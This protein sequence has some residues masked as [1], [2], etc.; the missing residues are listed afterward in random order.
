MSPACCITALHAEVRRRLQRTKKRESGEKHQALSALPPSLQRVEI[1]DL[2]VGATS[3][4]LA[5]ERYSNLSA[6]TCFVELGTRRYSRSDK[7]DLRPK[8]HS[9]LILR[10]HREGIPHA[11]SLL[12]DCIPVRQPERGEDVD[13]SNPTA[14]GEGRVCACF[15]AASQPTSSPPV[16]P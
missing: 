12:Q 11:E 10:G 3:L 9:P 13:Q 4:D 2:V 15:L 14:T 5:S 7:P 8:Q 6:S 16:A 1:R